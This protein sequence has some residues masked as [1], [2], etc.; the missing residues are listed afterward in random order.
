MLIIDDVHE[1]SNTQ[2]ID[3]LTETVLNKLVVINTKICNQKIY[4]EIFTDEFPYSLNEVILS[5][6]LEEQFMPK[7]Y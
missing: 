1:N 5:G 7:K 2:V 3:F 4:A 6:Y